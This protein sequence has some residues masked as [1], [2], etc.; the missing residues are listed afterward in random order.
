MVKYLFFIAVVTSSLLTPSNH[1]VNNR[2]NTSF[3]HVYYTCKYTGVIKQ[4][5][6]S[7]YI[8]S[9]QTTL[10][11]DIS[12]QPSGTPRNISIPDNAWDGSKGSFSTTL[13]FTA[14]QSFILTM[15]DATGFGTGGNSDL[16]TVGGS[17]NNAQC[18]TTS[19]GSSFSFQSSSAI[20]QCGTYTIS[21]FS[22]APQRKFDKSIF[23]IA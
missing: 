17:A 4:C 20:Q 1:V 8:S 23:I 21:G 13:N 2:W 14:G 6:S 19:P 12:S 11:A 15:S 9:R 10:I 3:L 7:P 22:D 16:L 5:C 18:N